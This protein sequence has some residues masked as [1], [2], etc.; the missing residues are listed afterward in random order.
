MV[1][2]PNGTRNEGRRRFAFLYPFSCK[3]GLTYDVLGLVL[4]WMGPRPS[5][6]TKVYRVARSATPGQLF[7]RARISITG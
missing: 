6:G 5:A 7:Q 2:H 4:A 1:I 3:S